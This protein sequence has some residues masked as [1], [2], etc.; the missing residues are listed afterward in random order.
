CLLYW[1][2]FTPMGRRLLFVGRGRNV[3]RLSGISVK[4]VRF[5]AL[6]ASGVFAAFAGIVYDGSLGGSNPTAGDAYLRPSFASA[7]LGATSIQPGR[8]NPWGTIIAVYFLGTG[9]TGLQL[10]G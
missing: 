6:V 8:F 4:R 3:A 5:G 9:I 10:M 7:F 1:F 2:E